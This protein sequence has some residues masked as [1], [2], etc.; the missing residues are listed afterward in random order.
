MRTDPVASSAPSASNQLTL[1]VD[2][3]PG[4]LFAR[5]KD[6]VGMYVDS[7]KSYAQL[8]AGGLALSAA[9]AEKLLGPGSWQH[10]DRWLFAATL[11]F[12]LAVLLSASYQ[13]VATARL[14]RLSGLPIR[15]KMRLP[16]FVTNRSYLLCGAM[17]GCFSLG[18]VCLA[19][20]TWR[21]L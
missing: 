7:A 4:E 10:P 3:S 12:L 20:L 18:A 2:L 21:L 5:E 15:R 14:E 17:I 19:V 1:T 6:V 9:L 11:F 8:A 16:D 13:Y